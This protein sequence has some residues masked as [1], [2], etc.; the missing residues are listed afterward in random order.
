[1][2]LSRI[3]VDIE[4]I[5]L[6]YKQNSLAAAAAAFWYKYKYKQKQSHKQMNIRTN[7]YSHTPIH[8]GNV[9]ALGASPPQMTQSA[10][11]ATPK[12]NHAPARCT[13][14]RAQI[15]QRAL[16]AYLVSQVDVMTSI[17]LH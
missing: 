5:W 13:F 4:I 17:G 7:I 3:E 16:R 15:Q 8:N 14:A 9:Y 1:M 2:K 12:V 6:G 10:S 11:Y